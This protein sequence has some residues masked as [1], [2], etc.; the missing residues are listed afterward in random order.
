M[1][2]KPEKLENRAETKPTPN[3]KRVEKMQKGLEGK[4]STWI[5][6]VEIEMEVSSHEAIESCKEL[7]FRTFHPRDLGFGSGRDGWYL[8]RSTSY[9]IKL[10]N[11]P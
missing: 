11:F 2:R 8:A 7:I 10:V 9:D 1:G 5:V 3:P 4:K 6:T